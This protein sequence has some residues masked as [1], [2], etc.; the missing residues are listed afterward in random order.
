M[1]HIT[2]DQI[3]ILAEK[4]LAGT[5]TP[6]E[7]SVLEDWLTR[8]VPDEW[9]WDGADTDETALR[10]RLLA[11]I[12]RDAGIDRERGR[13]RK[14]RLAKVAA[15]ACLV[16]GGILSY[17]YAV[18]GKP[19]GAG[20]AATSAGVKDLPPGHNGAILTLSNGHEIVLDSV[21]NGNVALQGTQRLVKRN[22]LL[23][24]E[25]QPDRSVPAEGN[26]TNI[27][28]TPRGREFEIVL[29][30]GTRVWLNAA[31]SITYPSVFTGSERKVAV[32]GEAYFEVATDERHPFVVSV[33]SARI[34]VLGTHFDVMAYPD[35]KSVKTTLLE[36][37]V[38]V[39]SASSEVMV[40]PGQQAV[41]SPDSGRI[42]LKKVDAA[43]SVAWV[44]GKL[45][46]DNLGIEA[47]M[48]QVS[49]WYDVDVRFEG[50]VPQER[51]WGVINRNVNLSSVLNVMNANGISARLENGD[52]IVSSK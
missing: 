36:G 37:A 29:S 43:Q 21:T 28:K 48:R 40:V 44:A 38:K 24:Y 26:L 47:I 1:D 18:T 15:V 23:A 31:S 42:S 14:L 50:P 17:R 33:G 34:A 27:L 2:Q 45:S 25:K 12:R 9:E 41:L 52:I 35:E 16:V 46:L 7:S 8:R 19:D 10:N 20:M 6:E 49:R 3:T 4:K 32:T 39:I 51:F 11:S 22:G 30:D 13:V 5:I